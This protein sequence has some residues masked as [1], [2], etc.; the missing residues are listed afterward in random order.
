MRS[1]VSFNAQA[2]RHVGRIFGLENFSRR[3]TNDKVSLSGLPKI[4]CA[5]DMSQSGSGVF[6]SCRR[7]RRKRSLSS[8]P[9]G[10]ILDLKSLLVVLT[11]TSALPFDCG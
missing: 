9:V 8:E 3:F 5:G 6:L 11:A 10:P 1:D 4:I 7:A 2:S